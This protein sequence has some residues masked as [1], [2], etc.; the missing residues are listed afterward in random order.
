MLSAPDAFALYIL[1][2]QTIDWY[3]TTYVEGAPIDF[4]DLAGALAGNSVQISM[5][6]LETDCLTNISTVE[7]MEL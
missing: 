6:E 3:T 7:I 1:L 2:L 4:F 5:E